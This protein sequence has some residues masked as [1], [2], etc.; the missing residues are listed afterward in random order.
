MGSFTPIIST[1]YFFEILDDG[2]RKSSKSEV[3]GIFKK[4]FHG[5]LGHFTTISGPKQPNQIS[6]NQ[7]MMD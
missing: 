2:L 5:H 6:T 4:V 3:Y 7:Y 1:I